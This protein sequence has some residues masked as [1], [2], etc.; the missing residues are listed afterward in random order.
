MFGKASLRPSKPFGCR[1]RP[2]TRLAVEQLEERAVP[3]TIF[4]VTNLNDA[5]PGSLRQGINDVNGAPRVDT[6]VFQPG[7][8]GPIT[9]TTGE[10]DVMESVTI[11]GPGA[12]VI[13]VSGNNASR[14]FVVENAAHTAINVA[15]SGLTLTA[16]SGGA[17]AVSDEVLTLRG[18]VITDSK[19]QSGGGIFVST[20]GQLT[21]EASTISGN[22]A[23][24]VGTPLGGGLYLGPSSVALVRNSTIS[25]NQ[26]IAGE[27]GGVFVDGGSLTVENSTISGNQAITG[28]GG[29][30]LG[31]RGGLLTVANST[32][33]GNVA[34]GGSGIVATEST[35][36]VESSTISDNVASGP[37]GGL[38]LAGG[39]TAVIRNSTVAF[40]TAA[41]AGGG[42]FVKPVPSSA[43]V[44][45]LSTIVADNN[46]VGATAAGPDIFG[47]VTAA[48]SLV[49]NV[50]ATTFLPGSANNLLGLDPRLGPLQ[51][52]G[53]PTK[54]HALLAG[55][56]AIDHGANP[57]GLAFDQRGAGFAR[58]RGAAPDIGAFEAAPAPQIVAVVFR[59][60]G[61]SRV[62]VKDAATGAVR[63]VLI[64]FKGFAGRLRL[65]LVDVNGDGSFDLIVRAVI[66][67]KRK[68]KVY[69]AV[70]L[71]PLP[72]GLA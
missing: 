59:R 24:G 49:E 23:D 8:A 16:G 22:R 54:T 53:G 38:S 29:G 17:V 48:F 4:T 11:T 10:L 62:R 44:T 20:D 60:R 35:L 21:L 13:T 69:D 34:S 58:G 1:R 27:G 64:P 33:S 3:S 14:I 42:I 46:A 5:G 25:G 43:A 52:N 26:V 65:Q 67:G 47:N 61:V 70:T 55:S 32:I 18:V 19:A 28:D 51:L 15:I 71:A 56:P 12:G 45:L 31:A 40:N 36:T 63:G 9:L 39:T 57:A 41:R 68:K 72:P 50:A 66:H 6:I 30:G 7:L 37:G 2:P